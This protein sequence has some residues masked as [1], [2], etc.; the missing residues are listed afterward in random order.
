MVDVAQNKLFTTY[1]DSAMLVYNA[2]LVTTNFIALANK[3]K[4]K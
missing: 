3:A 4:K 1:T 2:N